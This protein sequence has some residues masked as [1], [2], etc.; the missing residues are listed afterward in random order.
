MVK[1]MAKLNVI[2]A[3]LKTKI[4][5]FIQNQIDLEVIYNPIE[6]TE[7][8]NLETDMIKLVGDVRNIQT[9]EIPA[10]EIAVAK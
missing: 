8:P 1:S 5:E 2:I 9:V 3:E 7:I 4:A 6:T 10:L